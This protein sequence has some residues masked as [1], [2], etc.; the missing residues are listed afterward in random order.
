M[1]VTWE[2][3]EHDG[4][5]P[6]TGYIVE[7]QDVKRATWIQVE[8]VRAK[9]LH[10]DTRQT[11]WNQINFHREQYTACF[12]NKHQVES[13]QFNFVSSIQKN[14]PISPPDQTAGYLLAHVFS[15]RISN[16]V[17]LLNVLTDALL[18]IKS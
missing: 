6:I 17:S 12:S 3:S 14:K 10:L 2:E 9:T 8:K 15:A 13:T 11:P 1:V 5:S 16:A 7:K 4:G 18:Q